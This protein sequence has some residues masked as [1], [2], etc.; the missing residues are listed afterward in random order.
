MNSDIGKKFDLTGVDNIFDEM[1]TRGFA[2]VEI[3]D[4][5]FDE[6]AND[7]V[8]ALETESPQNES[9][10]IEAFLEFIDGRRE[11]FSNILLFKPSKSELTVLPGDERLERQIPLSQFSCVRMSKMSEEF[12]ELSGACH[13]ET[14]ETEDGN[15]YHANVPVEQDLSSGFIGVSVEDQPQFKYFFFP[16]ANVKQRYQKRYLGE[17]LIDK[18]MISEQDFLLALNELNKLKSLKIGQI[19]AQKANINPAIVEKV[20]HKAYNIEKKTGLKA[21]EI[22]VAAGLV[23]EEQVK[24]A[25]VI[26]QRLKMQKIGQFLIQKKILQEEQVYTALA[27]KFRMSFVDLRSE[28]VSRQA[29]N[30]FPKELILKYQVLPYSIKESTLYVGTMTPDNPDIRKIVSRYS[31]EHSVKLTLIRPTQLLVAIKKLSQS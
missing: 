6:L 14:V 4:Y 28:P 1:V 17:I 12:F 2:S 15:T 3:D 23:T 10:V 30:L 16:H 21:G 24:M 18:G 13:L 25:L 11:N 20:I 7:F 22:L 5:L 29:F 26:Q 31:K 9:N 27:E 19:I 8:A